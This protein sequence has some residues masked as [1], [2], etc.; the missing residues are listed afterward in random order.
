M[1]KQ[2]DVFQIGRIGK[3]H[4]VKGE[5]TFHFTDDIFD[6]IDAD[7]LIL[8]VDGILVPFFME[9]Y[10]FRSDETALVSFC[11]VNTQ[12]RAR[13]LTGCPVFFLRSDVPADDSGE[14]SW[15]Q[16]IGFSILNA[17][18]QQSVG[19]LV[20]VDDTTINTLFEIETPD[21]RQVLLPASDD[22]IT[23]VDT[24]ARTISLIIPDGL[25]GLQ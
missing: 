25:L 4:G 24:A 12:E 7:Y 2:E 11:D 23:D 9:E 13:E 14:L 20:A 5:V 1:I 8:E 22:L 6:R 10:R 15:A 19:T 18:K 21:G 3:A 16:V 17:A